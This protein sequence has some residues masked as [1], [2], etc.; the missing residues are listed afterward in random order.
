[1]KFKGSSVAVSTS[2]EGFQGVC[3]AFG[4]EPLRRLRGS[5]GMRLKCA[6]AS[7]NDLYQRPCLDPLLVHMTP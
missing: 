4:V 6:S 7:S 2:S 1:M 5:H 3:A